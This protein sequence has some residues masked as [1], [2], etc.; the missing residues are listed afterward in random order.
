MNEAA[1]EIAAALSGPGADGPE[2][3]TALR[4]LSLAFRW[5]AAALGRVDGGGSG[6]DAL[7]A[8][9]AFEDALEE[10]AALAGA[11]PALLAAAMPG[12]AFGGGTEALMRRLTEVRAEVREARERA[13]LAHAALEKL[14]AAEETL[15]GRLAEHRALRRQVDE[16]RRLER[17]VLALDAL[18]EQQEVIAERLAALRGRDAGVEGTLRTSSDALVRLTED[19]LAALAPQTREVLE[20]AEAAQRALSAE[21]REHGDVAAEL[22]ERQARLERIRDAQGDR[23]ASL[24]RYAAVD[25]DL[26]GALATPGG[27]PA[28]VVAPEHRVALAEVEAVAGDIERRLGEADAALRRVLTERAGRDGDGKSVVRRTD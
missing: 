2:A 17:L 12:D 20:R 28:G 10:S 5:A 19:Q 25:R 14:T 18:Q 27:A 4:V 24:R 22:A 23:V 13:D 7:A 16:L 11:L 15:R 3:E 26:A 1:D 8:L 21:E 6:A 9:F